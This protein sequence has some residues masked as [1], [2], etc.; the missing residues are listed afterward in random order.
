MSVDVSVDVFAIW[1][2]IE[3]AKELSVGEK[4]ISGRIRSDGSAPNV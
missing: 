4:E 3:G 1:D 2:D